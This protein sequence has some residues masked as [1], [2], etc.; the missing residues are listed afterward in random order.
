[1]QYKALY[2]IT[3]GLCG[4]LLISSYLRFTIETTFLANWLWFCDNSH[5]MIDG[6][7]ALG[8]WNVDPLATE[9]DTNYLID[10][11]VG[12]SQST[13]HVNCNLLAPIWKTYD[14]HNIVVNDL[15]IWMK[16]QNNLHQKM[17]GLL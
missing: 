10:T 5:R 16:S 13:W 1:M 11:T 2:V 3:C 17:V 15:Y 8:C 6:D 7:F 14:V 12:K 4:E 9:I